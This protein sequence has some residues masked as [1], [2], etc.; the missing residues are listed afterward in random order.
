MRGVTAGNI[1]LQQ[2]HEDEEAT[3]F[4]HALLHQDLTSSTVCHRRL[5]EH[6]RTCVKNESWSRTG[7]HKTTTQ[8][9]DSPE[10]SE[11]NTRSHPT[12]M[13]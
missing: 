7:P 13:L 5:E 4:G 11:S 2:K 12:E 10:K 6:V 1:A 3:C 9:L 8:T